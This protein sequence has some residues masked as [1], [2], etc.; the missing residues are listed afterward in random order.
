MQA[1]RK[2]IARLLRETA[3]KID[4]GSCEMSESEAMDVLRVLSHER[5]S[6]AQACEY[7]NMSRSRFDDLIREKRLPKGKKEK[8]YKELKWYKDELDEAVRK[9]KDK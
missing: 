3:N 7:L 2:M 9:L 6:K 8:G 5:M 4:A 1:L